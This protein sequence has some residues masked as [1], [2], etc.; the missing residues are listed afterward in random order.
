MKHVHSFQA[1]NFY[2]SWSINYAPSIF[3][4]GGMRGI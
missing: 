3:I 4:E 1:T 2:D